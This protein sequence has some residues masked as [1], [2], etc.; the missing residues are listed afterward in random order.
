MQSCIGVLVANANLCPRVVY[1][2]DKAYGEISKIKAL[3]GSCTCFERWAPLMQCYNMCIDV[4]NFIPK[5]KIKKNF[6][7]IKYPQTHVS[8]S[9]FLKGGH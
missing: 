5:L 4:V 9:I 3:Q 8:F 1:N 2:L 6:V 7:G